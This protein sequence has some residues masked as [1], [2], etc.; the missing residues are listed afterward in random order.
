[1]TETAQQAYVLA[2]SL[3][4]NREAEE[5][6][7]GSILIAGSEAFHVSRVEL[8]AGGD[9]FFIHRNRF[10]WNACETLINAGS[11]I[12]MLLLIDQLE[13]DGTLNEIGGSAYLT[14]LINQVPTSL[15]AGKYAALVHE[16]HVRRNLLSAANE[17]AALAYDSQQNTETVTSLATHKLSTAVKVNS[18]KSTI[19][20]ADS[21]RVVDNL[22][23]ERSRS[24]ELPG[25]PTPWID[26]NKLLGGGAQKTDLNLIAGRPGKGKT[27]AIMQ[28]AMH[29]SRYK[30]GANLRRNHIAFFSLEMPHEQLT[31][32][33]LAQLTGIDYQLLRAGRVPDE[34]NDDYEAALALLEDMTISIDAKAAMTPAYIRSRCEI[35]A[36]AGTL[37]MI[38][39][40]SLNLMKAGSGYASKREFGE[41]DFCA[42]EL[43]NIASDFA[44]PVWA[45]HQLN[46][47]IEARNDNA[48]PQLSDLRD[49][50]EQP[51]DGVTFIWHETEEVNGESK[52][53]QSAFVQEKQRNGPTGE[54]P[55]IWQPH[56]TR[57][58]DAQRR[59]S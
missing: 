20:L 12:D 16:N 27:T 30:I 2:P 5:A 22:I 15:N 57:F 48:K 34:K 41:V 53:K 28:I 38:C 10:V 47:N 11:P 54:V 44:V 43:K 18:N 32:R 29:G 51:A 1:M 19:T 21:V 59:Y 35:L 4:H 45:T 14:A 17:I 33:L 56:R 52:V 25:I 50:G 6:V 58:V 55:I 3:P 31:L 26:F 8:P 13:K 39:V 36:S 46:R 9:E 40:D 42:T 49:G 37:D 7:L 23:A 24:A